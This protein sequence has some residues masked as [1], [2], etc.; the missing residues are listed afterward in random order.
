MKF[1]FALFLLLLFVIAAIVPAFAAPRNG[2]CFYKDE[3]FRGSSFCINAGETQG[4]LPGG[5][6]DDISSI[7]IYGNAS[8]TVY[9]DQNLRGDSERFTS[10]VQDLRQVR[11]DNDSSHSW[12]N[13]IS[14]IRVDSGRG[15]GN[16]NGNGNRG[17]NRGNN[18]RDDDN[19]G[20]NR[21]NHDRDDSD[22]R[23]NRGNNGN[24]DW[25]RSGP[26]RPNYPTWGRGPQPNRGA[27]FY[28]DRDFRGDYFCM[29]A[30]EEYSSLPSMRDDISSVRVFGGARVQ[31]F[32]DSDFRGSTARF[33]NDLSD[34]RSRQVRDDREHTW[35]NRISS[36]QVR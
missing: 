6:T 33:G 20:W 34:L 27:C 26:N 8:V 21:D 5:F 29:R 15:W 13:R 3:Y 30:G 19:R 28:R 7:R 23:W 11:K 24:N 2:A 22:G 4:S 10:D 35:N 17:W 31:V 25:G 9:Q 14:S 36:I 18:N 12:N 16:G 1:R 32:E